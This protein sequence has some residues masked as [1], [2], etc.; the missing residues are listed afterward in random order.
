MNAWNKLESLRANISIGGALWDLKQLPGLFKNTRVDLKLRYQH[1]IMH[2]VDVEE[3]IVFTPSQ[4]T[5]SL[6]RERPSTHA[7]TH[8]QPSPGTP[9]IASGTNCM[10]GIS[11]ATRFADTLLRRSS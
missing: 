3:L 1:V 9:P 8:G 10:P 7:S 6:S 5:Q 4:Y 11:V 2:L